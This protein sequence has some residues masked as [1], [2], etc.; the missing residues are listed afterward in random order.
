M[1]APFTP[2]VVPVEVGERLG[3]ARL[4]DQGV[5]REPPLDDDGDELGVVGGGEVDDLAERPAGGELRLVGGDQRVVGGREAGDDL[6]IEAQLVVVAASSATNTSTID[7]A[8]AKSNP[9]R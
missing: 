8:A 9:V 3:R 6:D 2:I 4:E 5:D 7:A 1:I